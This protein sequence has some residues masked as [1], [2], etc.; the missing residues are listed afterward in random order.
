MKENEM[1]ENEMKENSTEPVAKAVDES[2][3]EKML[4]KVDEMYSHV[5]FMYIKVKVIIQT[6]QIFIYLFVFS[7]Y[8]SL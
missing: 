2:P 1:R 7:V 5:H 3:F 4:E 8:S 6:N